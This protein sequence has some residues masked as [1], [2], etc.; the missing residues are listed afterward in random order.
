M[1]LTYAGVRRRIT[2]RE[3]IG[4]RW[5]NSEDF[6]LDVL[7]AGIFWLTVISVL[8]ALGK[9]MHLADP[10][11]LE[12]IRRQL[13]FLT[14]VSRTDLAAWFGLSMVAGFCEEIVFRGYLQRQLG[15]MTGSIF[16]G[17]LFSALLFGLSH[18]YEGLPRM[19]L[20]GVFGLMFGLLAWWRKSLR[21]GMIAHAF[22]DTV[23]GAI[24]R[25]MK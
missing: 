20:I 18:G 4:G 25:M 2:M 22:H 21:P 23:Q 11:K 1:A 6:F 12:G 24:L 3:L 15:A 7:I 14:P 8:G 9:L 10:A 5:N 16:V 13:K 19:V 17:V